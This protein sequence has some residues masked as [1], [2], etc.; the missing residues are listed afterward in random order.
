L[1]W[2][3]AGERFQFDQPGANLTETLYTALER[4]EELLRLDVEEAR[5]QARRADI[6]GELAA[7]E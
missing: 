7:P 3:H 1:T 6:S 4:V 2:Q 5:V